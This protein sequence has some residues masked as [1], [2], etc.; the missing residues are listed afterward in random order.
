MKFVVIATLALTTVSAGTVKL[1]YTCTKWDDCVT[2]ASC[3]NSTPVAGGGN[4]LGCI[5]TTK[6]GTDDEITA[7]DNTKYKIIKDS[8]LKIAIGGKC[9]MSTGCVDKA[10][11]GG[12]GEA[13][14]Y[15]CSDETKCGTV[16]T[17]KKFVCE[18]SIRSAVSMAVAAVVVAYAL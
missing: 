6:C 5:L 16:I 12:T 14:D 8:C 3:T 13:A 9:T 18:S 7:A 15:L 4:V 17:E 11:C 1:G 2:D 10:K